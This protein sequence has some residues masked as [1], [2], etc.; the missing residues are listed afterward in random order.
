MKKSFKSGLALLLAVLMVLT[1]GLYSADG[2]LRATDGTGSQSEEQSAADE[3]NG[4]ATKSHEETEI[5]LPDQGTADLD[6]AQEAE[7]TAAE[8]Q[9]SA[10]DTQAPAVKAE[11]AADTASE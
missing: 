3:Q 11:S 1:T 7:P 6:N 9:Q 8:E 10:S 5:V 4:E 2:F